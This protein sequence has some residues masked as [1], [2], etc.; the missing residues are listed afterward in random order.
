M[1]ASG[2]SV[3]KSIKDQVKVLEKNHEALAEQVYG[4]ENR[5]KELT[6]ERENCFARLAVVYLPEMEAESV[7]KTMHEVQGAVQRIFEQKQRRRSDLEEQ[8]Q[9]AR[10]HRQLLE[11]Q[12]E[13]VTD[14]LN[15]KVA[16]R[17]QTIAEVATQLKSN[18][19]Y[20][21]LN[22]EAQAAKERLSQNNRRVEE[23]ETE[24]QIKLVPYY[25]NNIFTYLLRQ[26]FGTDGYGARGWTQRLDKWAANIIGFTAAKKNY[27]FLRS[28]PELM[29][30]EVKRR[31]DELTALV[32]QVRSIEEEVEK[33]YGLAV[34]VQEGMEVGKRRD[35]LMADREV[36]TKQYEKLAKE[37]A[38]LDNTKDEYHQ[39]A[40]DKLKA[41]LK[42]ESIVALK[43]RARATSGTEDDKMVTRIEKID[44]EIG[45]L[46]EKA[47][48]AKG[49][50]DDIESKVKKLNSVLTRFTREDYES[51]RSYFD[52]GFDI[53]PILTGYLLGRLSSDDAWRKV[54]QCQHFRPRQTYRSSYDNDSS[55]GGYSSGR[56]SSRG[57][58]SSGSGFG[59]FSGFSGGGGFGGGG[60]SSG[61]GF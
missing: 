17:E 29:G 61:R 41:Y 42:G 22:A 36:V 52:D 18:P 11:T 46:R 2:T 58:S 30:I 55:G 60:F 4:H 56:S 13:R 27:D 53:G 6:T 57:S 25:N 34:I 50:R 3:H 40:L 39:E 10:E 9:A 54:E 28:I 44:E 43:S 38:E 23:V 37:R 7:K 26:D 16:A 24:S 51:S 32:K 15:D 14:E 33:R 48:T 49:E 59:G 20:T 12:L 31:Q 1:T 21:K 47:K 19:A 8:M 5:L 35:T 45:G